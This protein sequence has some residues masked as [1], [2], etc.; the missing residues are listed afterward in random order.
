MHIVM[1]IFEQTALHIAALPDKVSFVHALLSLQLLGQLAGGSQV[2]PISTMLLPH[3]GMLP[4]DELDEVDDVDE[5]D[6][7]LDAELDALVDDEL[8]EDDVEDELVDELVAPL[9]EDV[10]ELLEE[11]SPEEDEDVTSPELLMPPCPVVPPAPPF[12]SGVSPMVPMHPAGSTTR[13]PKASVPRAKLWTRILSLKADFIKNTPLTCAVESAV[14]ASI[15]GID[16]ATRGGMIHGLEE[17][18]WSKAIELMSAASEESPGLP[19]DDHRD[20]PVSLG[21]HIG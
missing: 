18:R 17:A 11:T 3:T 19:F 2:S 16:V 7:L 9:D 10:D 14:G 20:S 13:A 21:A 8:L 6:E 4:L 1:G 15:I 5:L 12:P